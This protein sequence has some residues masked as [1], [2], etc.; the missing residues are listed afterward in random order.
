MGHVTRLSPHGL[1]SVL[2][3]FSAPAMRLRRRRSASERASPIRLISAQ[4]TSITTD[5]KFHSNHSD[6]RIISEAEQV[7]AGKR[8][9]PAPYEPALLVGEIGDD[10][11][12][13]AE[14]TGE[15]VNRQRHARGA[16][17]GSTSSQIAGFGQEQLPPIRR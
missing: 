16:P 3:A 15:I 2:R 8:Q 13:R 17:A 10:E 12:R 4:K 1:F 5:G 9:S 6:T 7:A 11:H 14:E